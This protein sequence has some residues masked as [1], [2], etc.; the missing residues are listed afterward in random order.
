MPKRRRVALML[1]LQWP[2]KHHTGIFAGTQQYAQEH[3]W[4]SVI[5]EFAGDTLASGRNG[6]ARYDGIIAR[7]N[8]HLVD[9][10][11]KRNVPVANVWASSPVKDQLPGVFPDSRLAGRLRAEHLLSRGF[12]NLAALICR[13]E[14]LQEEELKGFLGVATSAGLRYTVTK[15]A[16]SGW[17]S[18]G[19]RSV[20]SSPARRSAA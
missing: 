16:A 10:A 5:D 19:C 20:S 14:T 2:Y 8:T 17:T 4:E 13:R 9:Q 18:G 3:D 12:D 1:D 6:R 11:K 15:V 7:A